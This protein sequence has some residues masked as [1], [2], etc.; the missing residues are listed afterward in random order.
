MAI[1]AAMSALHD[2]YIRWEDEERSPYFPIIEDH[3]GNSVSTNSHDN[4]LM[5]GSCDYLGLSQDP[6]LKRASIDAIE[7]FGTNTYAA[8]LT[9]GHTR[10]HHDIEEKLRKMSSKP[11]AIMFPSGMTASIAAVSTLAGSDDVVINDRL[12]HICLFMGSQL[13]GAE[14]RTF[15]H[16]SM[17]RLESILRES[18][19]KRRRI[20]VVDGLYSADGDYAPLDEIAVLAD[21]YDAMIVVDEAHSFGAVGP[22]GLGAADLYGV[23]D[24]I[25]VVVGTMSKA[26]GSIGGFI[27]CDKP[28][29]RELRYMAPTYTS[30]RGSAPAVAGATL[31]SLD[32]LESRGTELR[33]RLEANTALVTDSLRGA[34]FNLLKTNSHIVPVVIGDEDKTVDVVNW[35]MDNGIMVAT[36]TYPHVPMGSGRLRVGVSSRH[37][38]ADCEVLVDTLIKAKQTFKF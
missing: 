22:Q 10:L 4:L 18:S 36:F 29:E 8:Q 13:S 16:N 12:A 28:V 37:S 31:A 15:P 24:R 20:I 19:H 5:F 2:T 9:C 11:A 1:K 30:S 33:Q 23:S 14:I 32:Q 38:T 25:D 27:L 34:G 7:K 3:H 35:L 17:K 26:L 6:A 21:K